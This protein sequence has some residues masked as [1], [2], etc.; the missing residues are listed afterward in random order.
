MLGLG[1]NLQGNQYERAVTQPLQ[2][3]TQPLQAVSQPLQAVT[4]PLQQNLQLA[5]TATGWSYLLFEKYLGFILFLV[6]HSI[7]VKVK[8]TG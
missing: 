8:H 1:P 3:V 5:P 6:I 2:A 4:Q 7:T